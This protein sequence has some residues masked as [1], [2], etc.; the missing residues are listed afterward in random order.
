MKSRLAENIK[1]FRKER[2]MTQEQ[3]AEA[4]GVTVGA[5]YKWESDQSNPDLNLIIELADLFEVSKL[6]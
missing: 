3:L 2:K 4:M 6:F 1:A 5:V